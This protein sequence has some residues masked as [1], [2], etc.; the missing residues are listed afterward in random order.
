MR[1]LPGRAGGINFRRGNVDARQ[2]AIWTGALTAR[3]C[4]SKVTL[5][6]TAHAAIGTDSVLLE[7]YRIV[8]PI[9]GGSN[10]VFLGTDE[11]LWRPVCVKLFAGGHAA[12]GLWLT[13][14]EHFVQEAFSLSTLSH[15]NTVRIYDFGYLGGR[16]ELPFQVLEYLDG[17]SLTQVVGA[18]GPLGRDEAGAVICQLAGAL[19]EAH[20]QGIVHRDVKPANIMFRGRGPGRS[21]KLVD[22]GIAKALDPAARGLPLP[23]IA[24]DTDVSAGGPIAMY[25]ASWSAPEQLL[26]RPVDVTADVYSFALVVVF[27][28]TGR[29]VLR[30]ETPEEALARRRQT[31]ALID[32]ALAGVEGGAA[33]AP[34]LRAACSFEPAARPR[35]IVELAAELA[36][37]LAV[38]TSAPPPPPPRATVSIGRTQQTE[39][40]TDRLVQRLDVGAQGAAVACGSH[41]ARVKVG[42]VPVG[43]GR[44]VLNLSGVNCFV[45]IA[46][47][48]PSRAVQLG[49]DN[50]VFLV[51]SELRCLGRARVRFGAPA[52][53][54]AIVDLDGAVVEVPGAT[55]AVALDFGPGE[56]CLVVAR[57]P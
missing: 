23:A 47:A 12:Q 8:A 56:D 55:S 38:T 42:L 27:L 35:G 13:A 26:A 14:F 44:H 52:P 1:A 24:D 6:M 37:R 51:T 25:S 30:A 36:A 32:A 18:E 17:G 7:R 54:G 19:A 40:V 46:T 43:G 34:L 31:D 22:F 3:F 9:A 39:I 15:P 5:G 57:A 28:L 48:R 11:R 16:E 29:A 50:D 49:V 33:I 2:T 53:G 10:R 45:G 41:G 4:R 20:A 21:P